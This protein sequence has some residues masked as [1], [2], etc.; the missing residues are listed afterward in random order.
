MR[1]MCL[2]SIARWSW[3][4]RRRHSETHTEKQHGHEQWQTAHHESSSTQ[5]NQKDNWH[6]RC[7]KALAAAAAVHV[8]ASYFVV[9]QP[10]QP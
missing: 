5:E 2:R 6:Y 9:C 10:Q 8:Q 7:Y 3:G 1:F 4:Q